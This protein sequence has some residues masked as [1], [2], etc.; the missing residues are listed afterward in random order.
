MLKCHGVPSWHKTNVLLSCLLRQWNECFEMFCCYRC[1]I[2]HFY[3]NENFAPARRLRL[4]VWLQAFT[5]F[6][7]SLYILM[8]NTW[9]WSTYTKMFCWHF[10][11]TIFDYRGRRQCISLQHG[12]TSQSCI[13]SSRGRTKC[14]SLIL[15]SGQWTLLFTRGNNLFKIKCHQILMEFWMKKPPKIPAHWLDHIVI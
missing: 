12:A 1:V 14:G 3:L 2:M 7:S 11:Q 15:L 5:Y 10:F 13:G 4:S 9:S 8:Q 6:K